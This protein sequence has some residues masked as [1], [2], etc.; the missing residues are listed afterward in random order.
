MNHHL[1]NA[2]VELR[3]RRR[4]AGRAARCSIHFLVE[5]RFVEALGRWRHVKS[6]VL[7]EEAVGLE[8]NTDAL[9]RHHGEI[10]N[11]RVVGETKG[12]D[13]ILACNLEIGSSV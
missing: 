12:C 4:T 13:G 8:V 9:N 2:L 7:G 5:R 3:L 1:L 6:R 10:L 11:A